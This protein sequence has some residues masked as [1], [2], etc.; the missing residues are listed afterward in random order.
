MSQINKTAEKLLKAGIAPGHRIAVLSENSPEYAI[1]VI[2]CW[3]I[4]AAV[5]PLSTRYPV[6]TINAALENLRCTGMVVSADNT[7][8]N[9]KARTHLINDFVESD[10]PEITP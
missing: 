9:L 4:G 1:L 5:V 7:R 3:K 2:A 8:P 6:S 10:K